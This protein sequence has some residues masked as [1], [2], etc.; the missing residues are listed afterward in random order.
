MS[1]EIIGPTQRDILKAMSDLEWWTVRRLKE[2]LHSTGAE[3]AIFR[4]FLR[5]FVEKRIGQGLPVHH[6][7]R[8]TLVGIDAYLAQDT[9][10][11]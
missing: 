5:G 2:T 9:A 6:E 1:P 11:K 7:M 4:L 8:L 3:K 10:P